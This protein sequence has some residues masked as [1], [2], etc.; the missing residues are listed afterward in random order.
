MRCEIFAILLRLVRGCTNERWC[1]SPD[2]LFHARRDNSI[3]FDSGIIKYVKEI[4]AE[5]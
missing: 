3:V 2:N 4:M 5:V 1:L